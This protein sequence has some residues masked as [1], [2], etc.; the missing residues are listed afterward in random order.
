MGDAPRE[1]DTGDP[2]AVAYAKRA[3][4]V[5]ADSTREVG[6]T[7]VIGYIPARRQ[8]DPFLNPAM[9]W[10]LGNIARENRIGFL[11]LAPLL[12]GPDG[13]PLSG[14]RIPIDGHFSAQGAARASRAIVK[15]L[16]DERIVQ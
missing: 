7:L 4:R 11:D 16:R 9:E 6:A 5:M 14:D 3:F 8:R 15:Y 1:E 13:D 12:S 2:L 10:L